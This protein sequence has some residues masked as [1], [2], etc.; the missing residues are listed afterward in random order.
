[1]AFKTAEFDQLVERL[2]E[3]WHVPGLSIAVVQG[4]QIDAKAYG[5]A[6][7]P[8]E[9][10]TTE[11]IFD[12]ASVSKCTTAAAAALLV[13]DDKYPDMQWQTPVSKL[14]PEDFVL[15][16]QSLTEQV[17]LEDILS[18]RSGI[19]THDESYMGVTAARP[20]DARSLTR[21]LRNLAFAAPLRTKLLYSN[22]M[23]SVA[24]HV[25]ETVS[26]EDY[27]SFLHSR[28]WGPL[29]MHNTYQDRP[30]VRPS[31]RAAQGHRWDDTAQTYVPVPI[32]A[33]P[34]GRGAGCVLTSA[35]DYARFVR[36]LVNKAAPLSE[37]AHG[38]LVQPRTIDMVD[39]EDVLPGGED[40]ALYALGLY[41]YTYRGN[42]VMKH[43]GA[44]PGFRTAMA[45]LPGK[46]WGVVICTNSNPG[47]HV[48]AI[49]ENVLV[50]EVLGVREDERTDWEKVFKEIS[51]RYDE[52]DRKD[53][54]KPE[55][56]VPEDPEPLGVAIQ[57]LAGRYYNKGYKELRLEMKEGKVVADCTDRC[58]PFVVTFE[59]L[60]GKRFVADMHDLWDDFH[61]FKK[62]AVKVDG[63][64]KV[65]A[66][67]VHFE[68]DL[69]ELIWFDR[70]ED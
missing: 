38:A 23:F 3:E 27:T 49:L 69:E 9:E 1:M 26:G 18:H 58:F 62:A 60:S 31:A 17:T 70:I 37:A 11:T 64:G 15:P 10:C 5:Y 65:V 53:K 6:K 28:L 35:G 45:F 8:H 19:P 41:R 48:H 2:M 40:V 12:L 47:E 55:F 13:D 59:H 25:V 22:I 54:E 30:D 32:L 51:A 61:F 7:F 33:S 44:V 50:D 67:G 56:T 39:A 46:K 57:G 24:T 66:V 36:C 34:E 43:A 21:N 52:E 63:E 42:T 16:T 4:D 14:I 20:D 29:G 68:T